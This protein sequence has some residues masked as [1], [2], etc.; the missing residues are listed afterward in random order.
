MFCYD[1]SFTL[2]NDNGITSLIR[3]RIEEMGRLFHRSNEA[4]VTISL[5]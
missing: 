1:V 4:T 3:D 2:L 5:R